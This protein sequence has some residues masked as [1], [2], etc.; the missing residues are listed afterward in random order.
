MVALKINGVTEAEKFATIDAAGSYNVSVA[1]RSDSFT[2]VTPA[3]PDKKEVPASIPPSSEKEEM[4]PTAPV[5]PSSTPLNWP[6]I[7]G[8]IGAVTAI[9]LVIIFRRRVSRVFEI[10][11]PRLPGG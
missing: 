2:V 1:G 6:L 3:L 5:P 7:G 10:L 9:A 4:P 8:L 11:F